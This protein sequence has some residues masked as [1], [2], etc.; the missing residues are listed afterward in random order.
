MNKKTEIQEM[1]AALQKVRE[2]IEF[3]IKT[4]DEI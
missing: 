1:K 4:I 3:K 2:K